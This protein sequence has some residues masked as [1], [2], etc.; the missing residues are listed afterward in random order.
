MIRGPDH[1]VERFDCDLATMCL[2]FGR[3]CSRWQQK[4]ADNIRRARTFRS[5][6]GHIHF[7]IRHGKYPDL[8]LRPRPR[9]CSHPES[10]T[11]TDT[12]C[13]SGK[14]AV[15]R[16]RVLR[17][18]NFGTFGAGRE[19]RCARHFQK[20]QRRNKGGRARAR[21]HADLPPVENVNGQNGTN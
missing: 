4:R 9:T 16:L 11:T 12:N 1:H 14:E 5:C 19:L 21:D 15:S 13:C 3:M 6:V 2:W 20:G 18:I 8:N 7:R 17:A 10:G